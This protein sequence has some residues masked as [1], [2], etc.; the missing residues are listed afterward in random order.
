MAISG[1][2]GRMKQN[3][4][5]NYRSLTSLARRNALIKE[6]HLLDS[7][8]SMVAGAPSFQYFNVAIAVPD[9]AIEATAKHLANSPEA[10]ISEISVVRKLSSA[11]IA[12][13]SLEAGEVKPA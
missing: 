12:V 6:S 1:Q 7:A 9:K 13:L 4:D 10:E 8:L 2:P 11:E 5:S 3:A